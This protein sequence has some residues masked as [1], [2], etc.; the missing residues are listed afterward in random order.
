[1]SRNR[2]DRFKLKLVGQLQE[3]WVLEH[4]E[5]SWIDFPRSHLSDL[6]KIVQKEF[7]KQLDN[8]DD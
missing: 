7:L 5:V 4:G 1:M 3:N 6:H 2:A 8:E